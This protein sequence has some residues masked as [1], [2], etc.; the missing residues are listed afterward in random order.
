MKKCLD[1]DQLMDAFKSASA[2]LSELRTSSLG[3]KAYYELYMAVFDSLRFLSTYLYDAHMTSKHHLADLYEL[4]QYAS[5]I[6][7]RLYLM[8]TVA[9]VYMSI[10]DA[11]IKEIMKD[12]IEMSRGVQHPMRGLFLRHYL[13]GQTRDH[14]PITVK[15]NGQGCL[16]DSIGFILTNFI[17]MNKLWV[18]LQ[19]QGHSRDRERRELERKELRILVGTNLV[20]L[21]QLE[22]IDLNTYQSVILPNILEQVVNCRDVIAQEYLMEVV[23]QVFQDDF[24]LNTLTPFLGAASQLNTR[25]NIKQIVISLIDRLSQYARRES[26][27]QSPEELKQQDIEIE[28]RLLEKVR[29]KRSS[30]EGGSSTPEKGKGREEDVHKKYRGIPQSVKLFEVFWEQI[31]NLID[32]RPDL[33]IQDITALLVSLIG[34]SLNCY[35][36]K[37]EYVDQVL[38]F[39][40]AKLDEVPQHSPTTVSNVLALLTAP[41]NCYKSMITL[42]ALTAYL[43]LMKMQPYQSRKCIALDICNSLLTNQTYMDNVAD[44]NDLLELCGVLIKEGSYDDEEIASEQGSLA[45]L[46]HLF[47]SDNDATQFE[48]CGA[49]NVEHSN[50]PL[51]LLKSTKEKLEQGKRRVMFTF[52]TLITRSIKLSKTYKDD[53]LFT[54]IHASIFQLHVLTETPEDCA[55]LF[56]L[57]SQTANEVE[58]TEVTYEFFSEA[59]LLVEQEVVSSKYQMKLISEATRALKRVSVLPAQ[60][61]STLADKVINLSAKM[62]KKSHQAESLMVAS[63][64]YT[65]NADKLKGV[66]DRAITITSK[67]I[68]PV[69]S[70]QVYVDILDTYLMYLDEEVGVEISEVNKV[71]ERITKQIEEVDTK[72]NHP[73]SVELKVPSTVDVNLTIHNVIN[74]FK[75]TLE[76][77]HRK[78][79]Y[80]PKWNDIDVAGPS[81][82]YSVGEGHVT[83]V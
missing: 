13:S 18:R 72:T 23:I 24:Q 25:V 11:P 37:L 54:F 16:N 30:S 39:T 68:E 27:L 7:P 53:A 59:L 56:L 62:L 12:I 61:Y 49:R 17:E 45:R 69:T 67:L 66:L 43:P 44:V 73:I 40:K 36:D 41:I 75:R 29:A 80:T 3:P 8:I 2:M 5:N 35:P 82:R 19:H 64:V 63:G 55:R 71:I 21:S 46:V 4:V 48:V 79:V 26:E 81:L 57:A 47:K 20:R 42:L 70:A 50:I 6:V 31:V 10:P 74:H 38:S 1:A 14:L 15:D 33:S 52:P 78:R 28:K 32:S 65:G 22:E 60:D 9:S 77:I 58:R 34:L 83:V 76:H 51:Q